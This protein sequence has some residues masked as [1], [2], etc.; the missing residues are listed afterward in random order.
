LDNP[1][2]WL[3]RLFSRL[4]SFL[5]LDIS[6]DLGT[7][8][9]LAHVPGKGI[10]I[11]EPS[12]VA[13]EKKTRRVI[14]VGQAAKDM[15]GR[16]PANIVTVRPLRDGVIS[17][18]DATTT[19]LE[20]IIRRVI[21]QSM[22]PVPAPRVIVGVPVGST[23]VERRAVQDAARAAGARDVLLVEEPVASALGAG[24]PIR[25]VH[26]TMLM[27]L[28]GGTTEIAV[29]SARR[30]L[31][32]HSIRIAGDEM[33][34][35]IMG[36]M[37]N[38]YN[39]LIGNSMA[40]QAK[41]TVGAASPLPQEKLMTVRGRNLINGL[42]E[43]VEISSIEM[44][45]A[46]SPSL[47]AFAEALHFVFDQ[48]PPEIMA[49]LMDSGLCLTGGGALLH[50]LP[51][52]LSEEFHIRVWRAEDPLTCVVRG[53]AIILAHVDDHHEMLASVDRDGRGRL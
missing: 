12:W 27:D 49:D 2:A 47:R 10:V 9:T 52:R 26:S 29:F 20:N 48:V 21:D 51:E 42:P 14:K 25:G 5:S 46:L 18:Y 35:N 43:E 44:R 16:T 23:N 3:F 36:Y 11:N 22:V 40:E 38:K 13:I 41:K 7:A 24:L 39:L 1:L 6:I 37:R 50:G 28:G 32:S 31:Y 15:V 30:M 33:D 34:E 19:M 8:N 45:E 4:F 53:A 17:E